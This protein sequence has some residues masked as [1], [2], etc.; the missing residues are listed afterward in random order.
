ME[1]SL[2]TPRLQTVAEL[3]PQGARLADVG[4]DHAHLPAWLILRGRVTEAIASDLRPGPLARAAETVQAFGLSGAV[5]LRL[6]PGLEGIAPG[7]ADTVTICGMGGE[8]MI[9]ILS[10][11]PWTREGVLLILQPQSNQPKLRCWLGEHG[12][13]VTLETVAREGQRWY[14]I[15][16]VRGGPV[17]RVSPEEALMGD[18]A[19]WRREALRKEYLRFLLEKCRREYAAVSRSAKAEDEAR[20]EELGCCIAGLE[21][22]IQGL[23]ERT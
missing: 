14:P 16:T 9:G 11:A 20:K 23:E 7:E 4:T 17:R 13:R 15:L 10:V 18:P 12:Y 8:V 1:Q 21:R 3:V 6:C 19:V 5:S 22:A 2:L